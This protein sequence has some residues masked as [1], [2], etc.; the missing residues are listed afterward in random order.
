MEYIRSMQLELHYTINTQR[1]TTNDKIIIMTTMMTV[2]RAT[3]YHGFQTMQG[4]LTSSFIKIL[5]SR[6]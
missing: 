3:A 1:F 6:G 5:L 4:M 2:G